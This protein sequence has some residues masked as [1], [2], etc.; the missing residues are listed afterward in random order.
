MKERKGVTDL[1]G[2]RAAYN[3]TYARAEYGERA[4]LYDLVWEL[5]EPDGSLILDVGCGTAPFAA[6]AAE[7]EARVLSLDLADNALRKAHERGRGPLILAQGERLPLRDAAFSRVVCLGNLEHFLDPE[8]GARELARVL[9]PGGRAVVMLPNA[10][11]S[12]D[13]WKLLLTGRG[14]DHHQV[15]DRFAS[16]AEW[17]ALLARGGLETT[18]ARRWDKGK[19]WKRIFPFQLAYHFVYAVRRAD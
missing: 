9:T 6:F 19:G 18:A 14:A 7:R 16:D 5:L 1:A 15:I 11:Y 3:A 12:G 2:L 13:L 10:Y 8:Q 4:A 17:R